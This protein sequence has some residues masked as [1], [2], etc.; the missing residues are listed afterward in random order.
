MFRFFTVYGS[1]GRPDLALYKFVDAILDNRPIDI[2]NHGDMYRDFTY[3]DDL[4]RGIRLL[5]DVPP[6]RPDHADEIAEGDSLSPAAPWRVVNIGNGDKVR[7]MDFIEAIED[8]L[9]KKAIRNY[10]PMQMGDV[11]ATW[12]D[13][14]LLQSL[15]G[16]RPQTDFKEGIARFVAWFRDYHGK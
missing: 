11:P 3:V 7:L 13:N 6:E 12:A 4:V 16:Y 14:D 10:M 15:T 5:I 9:G 2:Y 1:W 8:A